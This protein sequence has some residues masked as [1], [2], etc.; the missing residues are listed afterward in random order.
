GPYI[1]SDHRYKSSRVVFYRFGG[2]RTHTTLNVKGEKIPVLIGPDGSVVPDQR[3]PYPILPSWEKPVIPVTDD[4]DSKTTV[5]LRGRYRIE[6]AIS[7]SSAGGVYFAH[8]NKTGKGVVVKEARPCIN[9]ATDGYDAVE[10]L[11]KEYRLLQVVA[12]TGI[13]PQPVDLFQE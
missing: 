9:G 1:L 5:L 11:K 4:R 10:L 3:L 12:D 7:F 8:D 13:A 6:N 2:I